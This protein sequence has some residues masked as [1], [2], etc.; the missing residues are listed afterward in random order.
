ML[1]KAL[2]EIGGKGLFTQELEKALT[3]G[4]VD[5]A[6]HSAKDLPT[7]DPE[8][9]CIAAFMKR[10]KCTDCLV[11][12]QQSSY[13]SIEMLPHGAR[14]G[15]S[16]L[17]RQSQLLNLR[18]D[19]KVTSIRGNV[20]TRV[21]KML[22]GEVDAL[23][24]ASAGVIRLGFEDRVDL[25]IS[26]LSEL[27]FLPAV[28]QG[29]VAVQC[30]QS[31]LKLFQCLADPPTACRVIAERELLKRLEGGCSL[32]LGVR[33]EFLGSE[34]VNLWARLL[35]IDGKMT[36]ESNGQGYPLHAAGE[37]LANMDQQKLSRIRKTLI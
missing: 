16:S 1:D 12:S 14:I 25:Q 37:L 35:S 23:V 32:P 19:L 29:S 18:P 11:S 10:E 17:R 31:D 21:K 28:G 6:V 34:K 30:R 26:H 5:I 33:S 4:C 7:A 8:G 2:T 36:V 9:L 13:R 20:D 24:L 27:S 22:N 3:D 15:T